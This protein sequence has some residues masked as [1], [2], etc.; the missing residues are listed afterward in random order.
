MKNYSQGEIDGLITCKK[1][2][3]DPP[4]KE[5]KADRGSLRNDMQLESLD[6]KME[7]A[8]FMRINERFPENFSIGLNFIPRDEPGSFC[9]LRYNGPHGEHVNTPIEEDHPLLRPRL[10]PLSMEQG[11]FSFQALC[12][13]YL[14]LFYP[15]GTSVKFINCYWIRLAMHN[16]AQ[17]G[18]HIISISTLS[19]LCVGQR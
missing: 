15:S 16:H 18:V 19:C 3:T 2:I 8:V 6:G 12:A 9:L 1:R 11:C 13:F 10:P 7:F 4:R 14:C 5:M 17:Y